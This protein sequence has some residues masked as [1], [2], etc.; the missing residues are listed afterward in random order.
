MVKLFQVRADDSVQSILLS[1]KDLVWVSS[2]SLPSYDIP[3][4]FQIS[5]EL[6]T[7]SKITTRHCSL[8]CNS[9]DFCD[10]SC[11]EVTEVFRK[12]SSHCTFMW[13][14]TKTGHS[15]IFLWIGIQ[16][17]QKVVRINSPV[18]AGLGTS[19]SKEAKEYFADMAKHRIGFK[20]SGPEDDAAITLVTN[21]WFNCW[22]TAFGISPCRVLC[23][24]S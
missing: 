22:L 18:P 17:R 1:R 10:I 7:K 2:K 23:I 14:I 8:N 20:Y 16:F 3:I 4:R 13:C 11:F 19:T 21:T 24:F 5:M 9:Y 6:Q 15:K 12:S